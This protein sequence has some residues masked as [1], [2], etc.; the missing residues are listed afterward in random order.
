MVTVERAPVQDASLFAQLEQAPDT[1]QF[2][3]PYS[4]TEHAR[5]IL[6][7]SFVYLRILDAGELVG[8]LILVLDSEPNSVE[9]RRAVVSDKGKGVGQSAITAMEQFCR[10]QLQRT[11]V[12]LDVFE[13]NNRGRHIYEKL[14]Y[15]RYGESDHEGRRLLLYQK[16]L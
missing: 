2:V 14:G 11:R 15:E 5:N 3:L 7:S 1:K 8:F 6:N 16:R 13:Y 9:F 12:W 10:T 4:E